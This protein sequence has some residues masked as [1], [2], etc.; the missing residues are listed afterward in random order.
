MKDPQEE[1]E[2]DFQL[3]AHVCLLVFPSQF[4]PRTHGTH[5]G[6]YHQHPLPLWLLCQGNHCHTKIILLG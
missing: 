6:I 3:E 5:Y 4:P 2:V 1:V